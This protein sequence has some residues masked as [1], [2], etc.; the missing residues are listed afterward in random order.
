MLVM[1]AARYLV[2][3]VVLAAVGLIIASNDAA[4]EPTKLPYPTTL[5]GGAP[6]GSCTAPEHLSFTTTIAPENEP[7]ERL[8]ISGTIFLAD[9][10]TPAN[11]VVLY[12]YHTDATGYYNEKDDPS[13]PRL[14]GWMKT[15]ADGRYQ[16][17]TIKPAPYP[18]RTTPAHIHAH[19]YGANISEHSIDDYWFAGD[20]L[21]TEKT[22]AKAREDNNT[23][24][25]VQL[26]RMADGVWSGTR[27]IRLSPPEK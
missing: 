10:E 23:P 14:R 16:F 4:T 25:E 7:G 9:G 22:R 5:H 18:R 17:R 11:D 27:D 1:K 13:H 15:N 2:G 21:I 8:N 19:V 6:C 26:T 20:D 3:P 24:A 12:V